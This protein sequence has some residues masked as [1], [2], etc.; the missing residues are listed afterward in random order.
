MFPWLDVALV[1]SM[2]LIDSQWINPR[3]H[4]LCF[5]MLCYKICYNPCFI[6]NRN[7]NR[8]WNISWNI[9]NNMDLK[10]ILKHNLKQ[11]LKQIFAMNYTGKICSGIA[12]ELQWY[13]CDLVLTTVVHC[14]HCLAT[15]NWKLMTAVTTL[16]WM[17]LLL[18]WNECK[19]Y[20]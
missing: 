20:W 2:S 7:L 17:L 9:N 10:Q 11:I 19:T 5:F 6:L 15:L 3:I 8:F 1:L 18:L 4:L 16:T 14:M 13:D 12:V